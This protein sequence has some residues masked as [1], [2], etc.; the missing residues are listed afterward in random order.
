LGHQALPVML[1]PDVNKPVKVKSSR[2]S[3]KKPPLASSRIIH[4]RLI[5][6]AARI[7][8]IRARHLVYLDFLNLFDLVDFN[9]R[10]KRVLEELSQLPLQNGYVYG[11][12]HG[13]KYLADP[14]T[15]YFENTRTSLWRLEVLLEYHQSYLSK[16]AATIIKQTIDQHRAKLTEMWT[17]RKG[18]AA[19][20]VR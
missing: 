17:Q 3:K 4:P 12:I 8:R 16:E 19:L 11:T 9:L 15:Y 6:R 1:I 7:Q 13:C 14:A 5:S 10:C 18:L 2:R 20:A